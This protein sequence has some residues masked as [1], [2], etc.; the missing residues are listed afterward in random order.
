[1]I[2]EDT[3]TFVAHVTKAWN[4]A[5]ETITWYHIVEEGG[6]DNIDPKEPDTMGRIM[7]FSSKDTNPPPISPSNDDIITVWDTVSHPLIVV[8]KVGPQWRFPDYI[9]YCNKIVVVW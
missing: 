5:G 8:K 3:E 1:L 9:P 7:R 2:L 4:M 6:E